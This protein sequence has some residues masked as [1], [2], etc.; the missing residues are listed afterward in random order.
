MSKSSM[1]T[2]T[3]TGYRVMDPVLIVVIVLIVI[4]IVGG[5]IYYLYKKYKE[6]RYLESI[7]AFLRSL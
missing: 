2:N 5:I 1:E 3:E 6:K 4:A 7:S